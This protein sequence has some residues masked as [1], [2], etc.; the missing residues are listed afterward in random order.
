MTASAQSRGAPVEPAIHTGPRATL[1]TL[2]V[3]A[4]VH[5]LSAITQPLLAGI[6][7]GGDADAIE[8]HRFNGDLVAAIGLIQLIAA[9]VFVWRGR[10]RS[11][12]LYAALGIMLAEQIQSLLG[13]SGLVAIHVP[14]GVSVIAMQILFTVWLFRSSA[15]AARA[16]RRREG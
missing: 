10:G 7:L 15:A 13:Y 11:W 4:V 12:A 5:T 3:L 2:R 6:Y 8:V 9:I 1:H 14:L 16:P